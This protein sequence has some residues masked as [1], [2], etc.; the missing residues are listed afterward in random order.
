MTQG[1]KVSISSVVDVITNSSTTIF[2]WATQSSVAAAKS[3]MSE[4]MNA[5]GVPGCP[6]DYFDFGLELTEEGEDV[7]LSEWMDG[8]LDDLPADA[9]KEEFEAYKANLSQANYPE[10]EYGYPHTMLFITPKGKDSYN[11]AKAFLALFRQEA[12]RDG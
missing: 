6:D 8:L 2:T 1:I 12:W 11:I 10:N 5:M 7:L 4:I 3:V 9:T